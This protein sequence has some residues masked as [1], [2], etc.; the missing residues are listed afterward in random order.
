M[1]KYPVF[2]GLLLLIIFFGFLIFPSHDTDAKVQANEVTNTSKMQKETM[3]STFY[4]F[5]WLSLLSI[6][7]LPFILRLLNLKE[8]TDIDE[9]DLHDYSESVGMKGGFSKSAS[10]EDEDL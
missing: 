9:D 2:I 1:A 5:Y 3:N 6:L 8:D 4:N 10:E 7:A